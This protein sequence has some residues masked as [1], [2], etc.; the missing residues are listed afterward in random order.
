MEGERVEMVKGD[1]EMEKVQCEIKRSK[2]REL[3]VMI[4][5]YKKEVKTKIWKKEQG[6]GKF[7]DT[8]WRKRGKEKQREKGIEKV[9]LKNKER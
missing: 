9:L 2:E 1:K 8:S 3:K 6:K 4:K 7:E 5:K